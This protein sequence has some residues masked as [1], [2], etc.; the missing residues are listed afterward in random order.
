MTLS[1]LAKYSMTQ[2]SKKS[3]RRETSNA[4]NASVYVANRN[5]LQRLSKNVSVLA[6]NRIPQAVRQGI[7]DQRTSHTESPSAVGAEPVARYEYR[8]CRVAD[9][10]CCRDATTATGWHNSTRYGGAGPCR[11]LNTHD[12]ELV[13]DSLRTCS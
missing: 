12:A 2:V 13:H 6:H 4:L 5:S 9:R 1:D 10:R 8:S 11:Q 7:L 3:H